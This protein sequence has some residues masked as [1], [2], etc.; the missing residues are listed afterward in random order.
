MGMPRLI[1]TK[2][3]VLT[4]KRVEQ[5]NDVTVMSF[6]THQKICPGKCVGLKGVIYAA[7]MSVL[8]G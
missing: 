8:S 4:H 7:L 1:N 3:G 2:H 6:F 5:L